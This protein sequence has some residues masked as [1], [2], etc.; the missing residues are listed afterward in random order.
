VSGRL[1]AAYLVVFGVSAGLAVTSF[2]LGSDRHAQPNVAG[3]YRGT[4][5]CVGGTGKFK[6]E[7][8][9]Q[10]VDGSGALHGQ[11][12]L[13]RGRLSG[14][15][16][17][18]RGG[19]RRFCMRV[20]DEHR[21]RPLPG[22]VPASARFLEALPKPGTTAKPANP[23]RNEV[24][25]GRLMLAIAAVMLAARLVRA[26]MEKVGQ[27][28]VMGEV[29]AGIL[30]G[31]T[32]LGWVAP[33]V[34]DYLFPAF[35]VPLLVGAANIG[36][37]FYLFLVGLELDTRMLKGRISHAAAIS[38]ASVLLPMGLGIALALPLY[39]LLGA[40]GK[41]FAAFAL[42]MGV[43][44]SITAFPVLARILIDRRMLKRT[45]GV[46]ALSCA[47]VDDVTA[48]GLL[49][50]A[51]AV[52]AGGSAAGALPVL[53]Y[54][55]AFCVGMAFLARPL[56]SR[57]SAAYDEAGRVPAGWISAICAG[58]LVSAFLSMKAGVA[59]IFGAFVMGLVMPRRA[60]L[61]HD[62]SRRLEEFI[63]IVL[64]PLFFVVSGLK[65]DVGLLDRP[66][67]WG[68]TFAIIGVAIAGK[69]LASTGMAR[70]AGYSWMESSAL[71]AL[72]NTRGLTEL[73]VLNIGLEL[74]VISHALFSM[75]VVMALVTTFMTAP[76]LR[77]I[78]PKRR[79]SAPVESELEGVQLEAAGP[80]ILVAPLAEE[81]VD[82]LLSLAA[83]LALSRSGEELIVARLLPPPRVT[84]PLAT[85]ERE[86]THAG[87]EL[88]RLDD[89]L[90]A[91]GITARGVAFVSP[92]PAGDLVTL[93]SKERVE[94]VLLDGRR[95]LLGTG[96]PGGA[97]GWVLKHASADVAVLVDQEHVP[98]IDAEHPVYV[99]SGEGLHDAAA[100]RIATRIA[101]GA[102]APLRVAGEAD[103]AAATAAGAGL[104]VV[105]LPQQW[106]RQG[107]GRIR[108]AMAQSG[109]VPTLFVRS[110]SAG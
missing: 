100:L 97:V 106:E 104:L 57:V 1:I 24:I 101:D 23:P 107:L 105:G 70:V 87:R 82:E 47:A 59:A 39:G 3:T 5:T 15:V 64:L 71:G 18:L 20:A 88:E 38:N 52:A 42:F 45:I 31:P 55:F 72:L 93:A 108:A 109:K 80:A 84:G 22:C 14:T 19:E 10:F 33:S 32:L 90:E 50:I 68:L 6:L 61:S 35:V 16:S 63:S 27:P 69:W 78:D 89:L 85:Q 41:T 65:T 94:L 26:L 13:Q 30:L 102:G 62:V 95:P 67:L 44:M 60:D 53:G 98:V 2:A 58:V 37:V 92:D 40:P 25:L 11:L 96:P 110:V 8:S 9:G 12:R 79:L 29:L 66:E 83:P 74:G 91:R 75:L 49:A 48:W 36:L 51:S 81:N 7:Q 77:F 34:K 56:L 76:A 86:L 28:P 43:A 17:C 99:A 54:A 103:E 21:L 46:L 73:I 4:G